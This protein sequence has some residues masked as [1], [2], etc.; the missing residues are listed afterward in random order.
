M[1][2]IYTNIDTSFVNNCLCDI[3]ILKTYRNKKIILPLYF[4]PLV[5]E[6]VISNDIH[7]NTWPVFVSVNRFAPKTAPQFESGL[8][9]YRE[10]RVLNVILSNGICETLQEI[11]FGVSMNPCFWI[12][13]RMQLTPKFLF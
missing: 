7:P 4:E 6:L 9:I 3:G 12:T 1:I 5:G 2:F 10:C 11:L 8:G 13:Y